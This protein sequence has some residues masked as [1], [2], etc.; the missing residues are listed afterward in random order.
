MILLADSM[1]LE[2]IIEDLDIASKEL[3]DNPTESAKSKASFSAYMLL[4]KLKQ[5]DSQS[6]FDLIEK[7]EQQ[8]EWLKLKPKGG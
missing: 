2:K 4:L 5:T 8:N 6:P 1:P 7:F 3:L